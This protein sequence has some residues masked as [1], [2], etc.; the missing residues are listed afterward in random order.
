MKESNNISKERHKSYCG[1]VTCKL[2]RFISVSSSVDVATHCKDF[3]ILSFLVSLQCFIH[4]GKEGTLI[5]QLN[6]PAGKIHNGGVY[7][8]SVS[9]SDNFLRQSIKV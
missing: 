9:E 8:V 5:G 2:F 1:Q 7:G 4:D 6:E 3:I